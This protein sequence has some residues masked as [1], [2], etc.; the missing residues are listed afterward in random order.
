VALHI[1]NILPTGIVRKPVDKFQL[2][3]SQQNAQAEFQ[4]AKVI[5]T[6]WNLRNL[7]EPRGA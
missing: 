3:N 1:S 5:R 7:S 6:K 4:K 2:R